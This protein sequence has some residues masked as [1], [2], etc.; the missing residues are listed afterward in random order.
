MKS[1]TRNSWR[2]STPGNTQQKSKITEQTFEHLSSFAGNGLR[3]LAVSWK[4]LEDV[5]YRAWAQR[6][7]NAAANGSTE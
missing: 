5:E 1:N 2:K 4:V 7:R 6:F 3:T